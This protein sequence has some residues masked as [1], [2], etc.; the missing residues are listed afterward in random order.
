MSTT[1]RNNPINWKLIRKGI[2]LLADFNPCKIK[3]GGVT[4]NI[5]ILK[6]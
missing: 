2:R 1:I 3:N 4:L 6:V 5:P